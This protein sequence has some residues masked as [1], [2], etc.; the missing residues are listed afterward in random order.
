MPARPKVL[1][2]AYACRPQGGSEPGAGW[3]WAKAAARDH[4]VWLLTRGKFAHEIA[5]EL[6]IRPV[7]AL[8][9]VPLELPK[10]ILRLRRRPSDVY[11]Y[12]PLWQ[13]LAR[14]TARE[15]HAQHTFDVIH[16]LTFAVDWMSA[17]VVEPS[18]AKVIWGPVGGSTTAPLSMAHWLGPRGV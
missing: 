14:R 5:E 11:W 17:G 8:T 13:G 7:P 16:H 4:D 15:L 12:Y 3:A 18:S 1:L 10:W 2:S 9:V 6:A